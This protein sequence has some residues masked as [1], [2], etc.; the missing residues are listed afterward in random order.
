ME[1]IHAFLM[2]ISL[3]TP[4]EQAALFEPP[5]I[6]Y[7]TGVQVCA[8][9]G[10][11]PSPFDPDFVCPV[12][13][14]NNIKTQEIIINND[15]TGVFRQSTIIHELTHWVQIQL[16]LLPGDRTFTTCME[17]EG[18]AY[19]AQRKWLE[20]NSIRSFEIGQPIDSCWVAVPME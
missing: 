20:L 9:L 7:K 8:G 3:V 11:T 2:F 6:I 4:Y 10:V 15:T 19:G 14:Y 13:G 18:Q 12:I 1:L 16:Q 5:P 17:L